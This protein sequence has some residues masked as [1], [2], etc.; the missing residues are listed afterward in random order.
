MSYLLLTGSTGLVGRYVLRQLLERGQRVAVMVRGSKM[1]S[2]RQRID[3]V[4]RHW[5]SIAGRSLRRPVV[6][7]GDLCSESI[8]DSRDTIERLEASQRAGDD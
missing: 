8:C 6:L 7:E 2:A 4:M 3:T 1:E 5:E